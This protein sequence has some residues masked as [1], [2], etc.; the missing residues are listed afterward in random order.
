M[1]RRGANKRKAALFFLAVCSLTLASSCGRS[2]APQQIKGK[3]PVFPVHGK[4]TL[5]GEPLVGAFLMFYPVEGFPEGTTP[6]PSRARTGADGE[7]SLSTYGLV[8]GAPTGRYRVT[9]SWKGN[10]SEETINQEQRD[11][12]PEKLPPRFQNMK[13][14]PLRAEV[15]EAETNL[16]TLEISIPQQ[17][18]TQAAQ[19]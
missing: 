17:T 7:F 11:Q 15:Q 12:L 13:A 2:R 9:A 8:D 5:N 14:T 19:G 10:D 4:V 1:I 3:L 16:P 18:A 6:I